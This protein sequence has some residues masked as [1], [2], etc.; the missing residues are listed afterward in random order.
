[1]CA[2]GYLGTLALVL[3]PA[4]V[5]ARQAAAQART[6]ELTSA[7]TA[8]ALALETGPVAD[9][10]VLGRRLAQLAPAYRE[11][12]RTVRDGGLADSLATIDFTLVPAGA[13]APLSDGTLAA[14]RAVLGSDALVRASM[15]STVA[16]RDAWRQ[17]WPLVVLAL[18]AFVAAGAAAITVALPWI[19]DLMFIR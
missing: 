1:M 17:T 3:G 2:L 6:A 13:A 5:R 18:L 11:R 10:A 15:T 14:S 16:A 19:R 4:Y 8:M 7:A 9:R 12:T